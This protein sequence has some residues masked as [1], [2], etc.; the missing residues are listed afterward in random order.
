MA[1]PEDS[2]SAC[3]TDA[4]E[5][6][7]VIMQAMLHPAASCSE[8]LCI[9]SKDIRRFGIDGYIDLVVVARIVREAVRRDV[10]DVMRVMNSE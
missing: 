3:V 1:E 2:V 4:N 5:L 9:L 7:T 6:A 10:V 8:Q